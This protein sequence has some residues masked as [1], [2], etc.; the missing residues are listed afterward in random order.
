MS[1]TGTD[2]QLTLSEPAMS[3]R[4]VIIA[5]AN[6]SPESI[7]MARFPYAFVGENKEVPLMMAGGVKFF[8]TGDHVRV[9]L[10]EQDP[11]S[12]DPTAA[13]DPMQA[14]FF[15]YELM[16]LPPTAKVFAFDE[17]TGFE[18]PVTLV[19]TNMGDAGLLVLQVGE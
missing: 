3:V 11:N 9:N 16:R 13:E 15:V 18:F 5:A 19:K 8:A 1:E 14:C 12:P 2:L 17:T 4:E 6:T 7:V 10:F